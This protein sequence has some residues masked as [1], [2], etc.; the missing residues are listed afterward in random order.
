MLV[1]NCPR[2]HTARKYERDQSPRFGC[3][4]WWHQYVTVENACPGVAGGPR[5]MRYAFAVIALVCAVGLITT[6]VVAPKTPRSSVPAAVAFSVGFLA[7][8]FGVGLT[9]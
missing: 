1:A 6:Y 5:G 7:A 8:M 2:C 3:W 9:W 4:S